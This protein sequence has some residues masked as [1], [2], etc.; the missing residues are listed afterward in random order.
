MDEITAIP[1]MEK[2]KARATVVAVRTCSPNFTSE[3]RV[4]FSWV[5]SPE[6]SEA[7]A[8]ATAR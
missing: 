5:C 1:P 7:K 8:E 2:M 4:Y 6:A 3:I